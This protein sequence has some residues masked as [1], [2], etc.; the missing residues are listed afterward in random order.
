VI[1]GG[2]ARAIPVCWWQCGHS[3]VLRLSGV[4]FSPHPGQ[5]ITSKF[6]RRISCGSITRPHLVQVVFRLAKTFYMLIFFR[7]GIPRSSHSPME[8]YAINRNEPKFE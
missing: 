3:I 4:N 5:L 6:T 1:E 7:D 2:C 8:G